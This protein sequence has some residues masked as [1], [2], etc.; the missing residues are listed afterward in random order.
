MNTKR[1]FQLFRAH[2]IENKKMLLICGVI[3]L[4]VQAFAF[5][6]DAAPE[7]SPAT[8]FLIMFWIAGTFFQHSL[9]RNNSIHFFNLPVTAAEKFTHAVLF[10]VIFTVVTHLLT[11]AGACIGH[12]VIHPLLNTT[13]HPNRWVLCGRPTVLEQ[14]LP[15]LRLYLRFSIFGSI[16]LFGSIYFKKNALWKT[17]VSGIGVVFVVLSYYVLLLYN[18]VFRIF[19]FDTDAMYLLKIRS[20]EFTMNATGLIN[21]QLWQGNTLFGSSEFFM[22]V[23]LFFLTLTYLRLRETEV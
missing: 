5:T 23:I 18:V 16:F 15:T 14:L 2:F 4:G 3:V 19:S 10:L 17:I 13:L 7:L 21:F 12:Y 11:I 6:V 8:H 22:V 20:S 9:K 1:I